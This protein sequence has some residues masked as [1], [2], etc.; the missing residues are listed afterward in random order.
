MVVYE[1]IIS[2]SLLTLL[3]S[4]IGTLAGFGIS[5]VMVPVLLIILPLPQ[6]LLLVGIIHW[7]NDIWK[8]LLFREGIRWKLFLAFGL[9]GI[10]TSFLGSSLSLRI[11]HE[12]LSRT[13]G[14]FLIVYVLFIV[15]NRTFK[16]SQRLSVAVSGGALT[17]FFA[18]IFGIGGE[19]NAVVL[20]AFNLEKAVYITTAGAIS[21]MIDSTRI[22]TYVR[23]GIGLEPVILAGFLIFIPL[24][25]IG[26]MIGKRGIEKIPQEKFRNFVAVFIFL[27][28]L[29]LVLLP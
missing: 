7:F 11:S 15:F 2:I 20:S 12:I 4:I 23:G 25:L 10:F 9:P 6:T 13:L 17:G 5:T 1:E 14:V 27:F 24:S 22:A 26:V 28:G 29:K 18:G 16:L 19:I 21:F 8:I 3:A